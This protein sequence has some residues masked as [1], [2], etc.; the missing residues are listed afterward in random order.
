MNKC[1]GTLQ[2]GV[3]SFHRWGGG[4]IARNHQ[5]L[6]T[7]YQPLKPHCEPAWAE[8]SVPPPFS[9]QDARGRGWAKQGE[10]P[11]SL[12]EDFTEAGW[13]VRPASL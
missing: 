13:E 1:T 2:R 7:V 10:G 4:C 5:F 6:A 12:V 11:R 8:L 3:T 9:A